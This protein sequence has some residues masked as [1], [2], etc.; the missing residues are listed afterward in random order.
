MSKNIHTEVP[1][2]ILENLT[3]GHGP[4]PLL[5]SIGRGLFGAKKSSLGDWKWNF[6]MRKS[7]LVQVVNQSHMVGNSEQEA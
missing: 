3:P 5:H 1:V 6:G 4:N 2:M 7:V